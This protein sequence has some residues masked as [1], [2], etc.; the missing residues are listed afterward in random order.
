MKMIGN[1]LFV[2]VI[3]MIILKVHHY[4][5]YRRINDLFG[6]GVEFEAHSSLLSRLQKIMIL[7]KDLRLKKYIK[8][9]FV[10]VYI[11]RVLLILF[12]IIVIY[13]VLA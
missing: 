6:K 2:L 1:V 7:T 10:E 8:Y 4:F 5:L 13:K 3:I 12:L 9:F 11:F